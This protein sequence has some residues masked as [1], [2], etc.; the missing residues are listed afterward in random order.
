M[1]ETKAN[2]S[3]ACAEDVLSPR[4]RKFRRFV[5]IGKSFEP[6]VIAHGTAENRLPVRAQGV[7]LRLDGQLVGDQS[8]GRGK[9]RPFAVLEQPTSHLVVFRPDLILQKSSSI[10][11]ASWPR[12]RMLNPSR[13]G[14]V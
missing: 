12:R 11:R 10:P 6:A 4:K 8:G 5:G 9:S 14:S 7:A 1:I 2:L 13:F 3:R